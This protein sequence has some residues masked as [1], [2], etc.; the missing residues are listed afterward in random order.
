MIVYVVH[1]LS[2]DSNININIKLTSTAGNIN[3]N[4]V[5]SSRN[6]LVDC[7]NLA[8][9]TLDLSAWAEKPQV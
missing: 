9:P 6:P 7:S 8:I 2:T 4:I 5:F 1:S 3:I